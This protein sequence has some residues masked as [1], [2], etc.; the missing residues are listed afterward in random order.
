MAEACFLAL[1]CA[2]GLDEAGF[3]EEFGVA[4]REPFGPAIDRFLG[5]GL[6]EESGPGRLTLSRRGRMLADTVCA[7]FV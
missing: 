3:A 2:E 6:L 5:E 7:E 4:P 1:R